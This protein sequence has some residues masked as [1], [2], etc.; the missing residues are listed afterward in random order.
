MTGLPVRVDMPRARVRRITLARPEALNAINEAVR[1]TLQAALDDANA[2][3]DVRVI[4]LAGE[5]SAFSAGGDLHY[6]EQLDLAAFGAF[7][8]DL[9]GCVHAIAGSLKATIASVQ[10]ACAGGALG[11]ALACDYVI[12][13]RDARFS[14]PFLRIGLTPDMGLPYFLRAR[15]GEQGARRFILD[16]RTMSAEEATERGLC[17]LLAGN[18]LED[19]TLALAARLAAFAPNA[20]AQTKRL[21]SGGSV[22]LD[23]YLQS[24]QVAAAFCLG[25]PEFREGVAAFRAKRTPVFG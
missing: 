10:G 9:L 25:G 19:D 22:A 24:E 21:L 6:M 7:H 16:D 1:A 4:I 15:L 14:A 23:Y 13:S 2:D 20:L 8:R 3:P 11:F 12:A 17:D 5:G 18:G